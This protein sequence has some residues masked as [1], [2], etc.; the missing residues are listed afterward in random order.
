[1]RRLLT[2]AFLFGTFAM[3]ANAT[4]EPSFET[5]ATDGKVEVRQYDPIIVAETEV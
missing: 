2:A 5:V 4:E 1:M 3:S